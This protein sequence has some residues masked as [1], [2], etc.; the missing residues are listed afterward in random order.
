MKMYLQ[1]AMSMPQGMAFILVSTLDPRP[2]RG[3]LT[4]IQTCASHYIN[5]VWHI[6]PSPNPHSFVDIGDGLLG[7][8]SLDT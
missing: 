1:V 5:Q 3:T 4:D 6:L 7:L 8:S 2:P